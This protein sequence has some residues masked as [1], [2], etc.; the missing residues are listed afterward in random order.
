MHRLPQVGRMQQMDRLPLFF[1]VLAEVKVDDYYELCAKDEA[2]GRK[3]ELPT[4]TFKRIERLADKKERG[5][6][7][8]VLSFGM[9]GKLMG[10]S[11]ERRF[12][13]AD[14]LYQTRF[15]TF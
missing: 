6:I 2:H 13:Y 9:L 4:E 1:R 5:I 12:K 7:S 10:K 15:L 3:T 14:Y 11:D 8:K